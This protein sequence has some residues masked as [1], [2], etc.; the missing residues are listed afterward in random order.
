MDK[1]G[2]GQLDINDIRQNFNAKDH[3]DVKSGKK[4]EDEILME[5]LDTFEDHF[6]DVKG[7]EDARDGNIT[8]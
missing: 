4:K 2:S 8:L 1:D 3:P 6:A 5:F 7:Q